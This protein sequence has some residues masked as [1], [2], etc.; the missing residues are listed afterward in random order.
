MYRLLM[1]TGLIVLVLGM[2]TT[3]GLCQSA[4]PTLEAAN[5]VIDF[6]FNWMEDTTRFD[7][8]SIYKVAGQPVDF[9]RGILPALQGRLDAVTTPCSAPSAEPPARAYRRIAL[10]SLRVYGDS[11]VASLTVWKGEQVFREDYLLVNR[12][13]GVRWGLRE[14]RVWGA[15]RHYPAPISP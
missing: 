1:R 11:A 4:N 8:C 3:A 14:I 15:T 6:R 2:S 12:V 13:P 5:T 7:A 10:D 9:P